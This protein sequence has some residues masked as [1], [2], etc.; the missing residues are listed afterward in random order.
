MPLF[1]N[2]FMERRSYIQ[3]SKL[4]L[5]LACCLVIGF[6]STYIWHI[7]VVTVAFSM[8]LVGHLKEHIACKN[9]LL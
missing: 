5:L 4:L 3:T 6:V 9:F 2:L 8:L 7:D 1:C